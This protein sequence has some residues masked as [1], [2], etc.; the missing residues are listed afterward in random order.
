MAIPIT[1]KSMDEVPEEMREF[2]S[3]SDGVFSYD[4]ER[5]F[6]ALKDEREISK[7]AKA[8][9]A[10]FKALGITAEEVNGIREKLKSFEATGKTPE[11]ISELISRAAT[12]PP[13]PDFSKTT[14]FLE[15]KKELDEAKKFR[16]SYEAEVAKNLE[17][18]RNDLVRKEIHTLPDKVDKEALLSLL[19][20]TKMF[21]RFTLNEQKNGLAPFQDKLPA[22][23]LTEFAERHKCIKTSTPGMAKPGNANILT[24][25]ATDYAAAREKGDISGMLNYCPEAK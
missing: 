14:E 23:Y 11:E 8:A 1:V 21:E 6:K 16:K 9:Y 10:P 24:G 25:A 17:N 22:D 7:S 2:V 3:E 12:P 13:K 4:N 5:A 20:E 19:D 18:L 15:M